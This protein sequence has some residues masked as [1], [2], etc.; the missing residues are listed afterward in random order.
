MSDLT[1]PI[2]HAAH[3]EEGLGAL[4]ALP[5]DSTRRRPSRYRSRLLGVAL[6]G[7]LGAAS[8]LEA[9]PFYVSPNG[10][11]AA[12]GTEAAPFRTIDRARNAVRS[13]NAS[14][15][16]DIV[17]F[18][19]G[20]R[21]E[22]SDTLRFSAN[23]SGRNGH[24]VVYRSYPGEEAI[25]SG[26][27]LVTGWTHHQGGIYQAPSPV[28]AYRQL[29]VDGYRGTRARTPNV[30]YNRITSW[31]TD[32]TITVPAQ[33]VHAWGN[34]NQIEMVIEKH[35]H[36]SRLRVG[37]FSKSG[38]Q[39]TIVPLEPD[40][41]IEWHG[42]WPSREP[43]Q[44]YYFENALDFLDQPGEWYLDRG[45]QR[46]YYMPHPGQRMEDLEIIVPNLERLVDITGA[47]RI[48][49]AGLTFEHANW[50]APDNHGFVAVQANYYRAPNGIGWVPAGIR[51]ESS[52][53]IVLERNV[54]RHMGG[55]AIELAFGTHRTQIVGNAISDIAAGGISVFTALSNRNAPVHQRS[56][57]DTVRNNYVTRV[58][59]DYTGG[60][61]I[62]GTYPENMIVEHNEVF[63]TPYSGL[64][65]GWGWTSDDTALRN[66]VVRY[67][68]IQQV[69]NLLDDGA[70]IYTL[71][72]QPGTLIEENYISDLT[73]NPW[74]GNY[75]ITAL[76]LDEQ[77]EG[78]TLRN[79]VVR[80][81]SGVNLFKQN[82][83]RDGAN[84]VS[85]NGANIPNADAIMAKAG[86]QSAY[87]DIRSLVSPGGPPPPAPGPFLG[88]PSPIPGRIQ[89]QDFDF[90]G[91][92]V[93][94]YDSTASNQGGQHRPAERVDIETTT[95]VGGGYNVGYV[96]PGEWLQYTVDVAATGQY[97]ILARVASTLSGRH[98][99]LT[100][101]GAD[102]T[103]RIDVPNTG[104]WQTWTTVTVN[105]V[106]LVAGPRKLRL[107][108]DTG[109]FNVNWVEAVAV[110]VAY[111]PQ[112]VW[113]EPL[114][115]TPFET[116][117]PI[118][119]SAQANSP[120]GE[121][122][123]V[124]FFAGDLKIGDSNTEPYTM[125]WS[126]APLGQHL[127]TAR[128]L[129]GD[130]VVGTAPPV[131]IVVTPPRIPFHGAPASIP[132]R[133]VGAEYDLGG[134]GV[135]YFDTTPL[136]TG[137][138]FRPD[139]QVDIEASDGSGT[140]YN[141]GWIASG[142]WAEYTVKVTQ[143]GTYN[144][145]FRVAS[146]MDGGNIQAYLAGQDIT[147][148][149]SIPNTGGWQNWIT[150]TL[151]AVD[152]AAGVKP[153]RIAMKTGGFNLSAVEFELVAPHIAAFTNF[154]EWQQAQFTAEDLENPAVSGPL[155][156]PNGDGIPNLMNYAF[157]RNAG[158]TTRR[159]LPTAG[160]VTIDG[161][162]YLTMAYSRGAEL[163]DLEFV[164]EVS[165]DMVEWASA[166][167]GAV[168]IT[169]ETVGTLKR[170]LARD[171]KPISDDGRRFL[172]ARITR[173]TSQS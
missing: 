98:F 56:I 3:S 62:L 145:H 39:A 154:G 9:N 105:N 135:S 77:S 33:Q 131:P 5:S 65:I 161:Q 123:R 87:R 23:D 75:E 25:V 58:G 128:A 140:D 50:T 68:R 129:D 43:N 80:N 40:R 164:V 21:Y 147:G 78:I 142:E 136:N 34:L 12:A 57:G 4:P 95:D 162:R 79:N 61:A 122:A 31:N 76:Y 73:R 91:P 121:I 103:G 53:D 133:I 49:L 150:A 132:G 163:A 36:Q 46:V 126:D 17:V 92:S 64:S 13:V 153:L 110:N 6:A 117:Q 99:R 172:R 11:D 89:A 54:M 165:S 114:A 173:K 19:R 16:S 26:G 112:V 167:D 169:I 38:T 90:G 168:Q 115:N 18:L 48:R 100:V 14:Q 20:G 146:A 120:E 85:N 107:H 2:L 148:R 67:N 1:I 127:L 134:A 143:T 83:V 111:P 155:A 160:Q 93:A 27:R 7:L 86:L 45:Q 109:D 28:G 66:N 37:S 52:Q 102:V 82:R 96:T 24:E 8:G 44:P 139:D 63:D 41:T 55:S 149:L 152:L 101:D 81:L 116:G 104:G 137:G 29:Y 118:T 88:Q 171:L 158:E 69:M 124:E 60:V 72:K 71:S 47:S 10:N 35:W 30:G 42:Q 84:S 130:G 119:L 51:V 113:L 144:L 159:H 170:V 15:T 22:L 125:V 151:P 156:A 166:K 94:Y 157:H 138:A 32:R 70:G 59:Q 141:I 74:A 108:F 106:E 97:N